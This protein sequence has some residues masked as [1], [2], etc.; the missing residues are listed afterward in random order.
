M[1]S[2]PFKP[3]SYELLI[4]QCLITK[5]IMAKVTLENKSVQKAPFSI[6]VLLATA[7]EQYISNISL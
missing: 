1:T 2:L 5:K 3:I 4:L 6:E 7:S